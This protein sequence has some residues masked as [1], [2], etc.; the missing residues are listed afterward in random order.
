MKKL[1]EKFKLH[2]EKFVPKKIEETPEHIKGLDNFRNIVKFLDQSILADNK[3]EELRITF[4]RSFNL[5]CRKDDKVFLKTFLLKPESVKECLPLKSLRFVETSIEDFETHKT[6]K[7]YSRQQRRNPYVFKQS[8][9]SIW[10][11]DSSELSE[12]IH[13]NIDTS[14]DLYI[15][16]KNSLKNLK[17]FLQ[18]QEIQVLFA[19]H[20]S[21]FQSI[22]DI[23]IDA[24]ETNFIISSENK[25]GISEILESFR[26]VISAKIEVLFE[27]RK[28]IENIEK[29]KQ[30][31]IL[32]ALE[33]E[34]EKTNI[35]KQKKIEE[36][37]SIERELQTQFLL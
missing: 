19:S 18:E 9:I 3:K 16:M 34:K 11:V 8:P 2:L 13:E 25:E 32:K 5:L 31:I 35:F 22:Y 20:S 15:K 26:L 33:Q 21:T 28:I 17:D 10:E 37:L 1:T 24:H 6:Y 27:E 29:K 4:S 30:E 12:Y 36:M 7:T 14:Q 23:L